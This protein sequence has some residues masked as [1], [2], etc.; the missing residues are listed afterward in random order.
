M[1]LAQSSSP[2]R[3][4]AGSCRDPLIVCLEAQAKLLVRDTEIAIAATDNRR[5]PDCLYL[6]RHDADIGRAAAIVS[7]AIEAKT[8]VEMTQKND[9]MLEPDI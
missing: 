8:I 6:L 3:R 5:W 1:T 2:D 7:E 9:V 4:D